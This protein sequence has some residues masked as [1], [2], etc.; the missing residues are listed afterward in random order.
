MQFIMGDL[1]D[2]GLIWSDMSE[3]SLVWENSLFYRSD[4]VEYG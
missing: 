4:T 2:I 3:I 1:F